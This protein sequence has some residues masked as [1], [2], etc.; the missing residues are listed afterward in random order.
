MKK[1]MFSLILCLMLMVSLTV[2]VFAA[3]EYGNYYDETEELWNQT[4]EVLGTSTLPSM[5]EFYG[6]DIRVDVLTSV[7]T[8]GVEATAQQIYEEYGYGLGEGMDGVSLTVYAVADEEGLSL[9]GKNGASGHG[10]SYDL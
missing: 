8:N 5:A 9:R 7:G 2:P 1:R 10:C 6:L 4:L 3:N